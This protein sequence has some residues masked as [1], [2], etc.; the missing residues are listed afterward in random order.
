MTDI[1]RAMIKSL[2]DVTRLTC[3]IGDTQ[4]KL[5]AY[6]SERFPDADSQALSNVAETTRR[7][8]LDLRQRAESLKAALR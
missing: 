5:A 4:A 8:L 1:E 2:A 3:E 7:E 6:I